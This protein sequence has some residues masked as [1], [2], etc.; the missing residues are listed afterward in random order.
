M[1]KF[2]SKF[3]FCNL[4]ASH[5]LQLNL[6]SN[7]K[8]THTSS[9]DGKEA[10][11]IWSSQKF[12]LFLTNNRKTTN[13][14]RWRLLDRWTIQIR[15]IFL[16]RCVS[17]WKIVF[18]YLFF[19]FAR[20]LC[21]LALGWN[22]YADN[23]Q[24]GIWSCSVH[25]TPQSLTCLLFVVMRTMRRPF[26]PSQW[27]EGKSD[28]VVES[29]TKSKVKFFPSFIEFFF[30][31]LYISPFSKF[32]TPRMCALFVSSVLLARKCCRNSSIHWNFSF[33]YF[34]LQQERIARRRSDVV[35]EESYY[36]YENGRDKSELYLKQAFFLFHSRHRETP[37]RRQRA[38]AARNSINIFHFSRFHRCSSFG[39]EFE[40]PPH[41]VLTRDT[42]TT[43]SVCYRRKSEK[44][45]M[46]KSDFKIESRKVISLSLQ[47]YPF[48]NTHRWSCDCL[49]CFYSRTLRVS[50]LASWIIR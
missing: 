32:F 2:S 48:S 3:L 4:S 23:W 20:F 38:V 14:T 36:L 34:E 41:A 35:I 10:Q 31:L 18:V 26:I 27:S 11:W 22:R 1:L 12:F 9:K 25:L 19:S 13:S 6:A 33:F 5:T 29:S 46:R 37:R 15:C 7:W 49:W 39:L 42:M 40:T 28:D 21:L 47:I 50:V 44:K 43:R 17:N 8:D 24:L 45:A 30:L 16:L